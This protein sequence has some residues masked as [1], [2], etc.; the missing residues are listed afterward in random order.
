MRLPLKEKH[1]EHGHGPSREHEA[2]PKIDAVLKILPGNHDMCC[3]GER[4]KHRSVAH[5]PQERE[6]HS[7]E[8]GE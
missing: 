6:T 8:S 3:R 2:L 7:A 1:E 5:H 4:D